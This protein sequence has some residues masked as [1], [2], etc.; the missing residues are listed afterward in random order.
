[1]EPAERWFAGR[2]SDEEAVSDM[3]GRFAQ[4]TDAWNAA[5]DRKAA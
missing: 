4:L 3:A 1:M 2:L 5:R